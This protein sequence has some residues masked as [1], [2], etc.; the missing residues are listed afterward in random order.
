MSLIIILLLSL[1]FIPYAQSYAM[2]VTD[3]SIRSQA[4]DQSVF[5]Y[6]TDLIPIQSKLDQALSIEQ[7]I[8]QTWKETFT[9][10]INTTSITRDCTTANAVDNTVI[11]LRITSPGLYCVT[12]II[13]PVAPFG[14]IISIETDNV[15]LD[16]NENFI[17]STGAGTAIVCNNRSNI[18][19]RGGTIRGNVNNLT[20]GNGIS[21]TNGRNILL[22]NL[23]IANCSHG[24][25]ISNIT[26]GVL[27]NCALYGN[28]T[29]LNLSSG[30]FFL[31]L[32]CVASRN[33]QGFVFNNCANIFLQQCF[34]N[35]NGA[36]GFLS[37][38]SRTFQ[39]ITCTANGNNQGFVMDRTLKDSFAACT[40]VDNRTQGFD[41]NADSLSMT[42]INAKGNNV[43]FNIRGTNTVLFQC[44][45]ES[46]VNAGFQLNT[47]SKFNLLRDNTAMENGIGYNNLGTSNKF[48]SNFAEN[49]TTNYVNVPNTFSSP[50]VLSPIN[51]T[52]NIEN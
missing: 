16:L 25:F 21:I 31:L 23:T 39:F 13:I 26:E 46:N 51:F 17:Q 2:K 3:E 33:G 45:A 32:S 44:L 40:S 48:Y 12:D 6:A 27:Q 19:I 43:G 52:A 35:N 41:L 24:I 20:G 8:L 9:Y 36:Q 14:F 47:T 37:I 34:A 28:T 42:A 18:I 15:V 50:T 22:Q 11:P 1:L 7:E 5:R 4:G 10:E 38:L 29:G 30:Q 49:N